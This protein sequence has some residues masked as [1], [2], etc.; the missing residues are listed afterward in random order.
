MAM[1]LRPRLNPTS[2]VSQ[3]GSQ[4]LK[5]EAWIVS[6]SEVYH[7]A[8]WSPRWPVWPALPVSRRTPVLCSI[9]RSVQPSRSRAMTCYF[10]YAKDTANGDRAYYL[11]PRFNVLGLPVFRLTI[12]GGFLGESE[13]SYV[14]VI[15]WIS[16][17]FY[18]RTFRFLFMMTC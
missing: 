5:P 17:T 12:I 15:S 2:M 8:R 7:W 16:Q 4:R 3:Y 6:F 13:A 9:R 11:I 14:V 1:A 10:F 18:V